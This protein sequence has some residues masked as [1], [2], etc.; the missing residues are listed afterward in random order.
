MQKEDVSKNKPEHVLDINP[1]RDFGC[2]LKFAV[3][4]NTEDVNFSIDM[5]FSEK[6]LIRLLNFSEK[7]I[8][9]KI[10]PQLGEEFQVVK[11]IIT[12]PDSIFFSPFDWAFKPG[13]KSKK[14]PITLGFLDVVAE[15]LGALELSL[16][17]ERVGSKGRRKILTTFLNNIDKDMSIPVDRNILKFADI[18]AFTCLRMYVAMTNNCLV[19]KHHTFSEEQD[20]NKVK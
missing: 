11:K 10:L 5:E 16:C 2:L 17:N 9:E 4:Q 19:P 6:N 13:I 8:K 14:D 3:S 20:L 12:H 7:H 1:V 18:L 15:F